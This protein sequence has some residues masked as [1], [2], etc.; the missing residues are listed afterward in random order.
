MAMLGKTDSLLANDFY[1][2]HLLGRLRLRQMWV[3]WG[4]QLCA[5]FLGLGRWENVAHISL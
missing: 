3:I 5:E 1:I 2:G 4:A